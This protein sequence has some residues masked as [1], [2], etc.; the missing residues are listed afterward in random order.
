MQYFFQNKGLIKKVFI[1]FYYM[2]IELTTDT[3]YSQN[4]NTKT[5]M[6]IHKVYL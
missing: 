6:N 5:L 4:N 3:M 1:E 2:E